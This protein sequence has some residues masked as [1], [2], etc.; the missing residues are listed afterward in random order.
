MGGGP[1]PSPGA[2]HWG[3]PRYFDEVLSAFPDLT[4]ILAHMGLGY[5][6]D[7]VRLTERHANVHTDTSLRL[8]RLGRAGNP[9]PAELVALIRRIGV[10]RT[11][12]GTNYPFVDPRAYRERL[13]ALPLS[14]R[15]RELIAYRNF[16]AVLPPVAQED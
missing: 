15:E 10:D 16:M 4:L 14:E 8:S 3:R 13:Q 2:D 9:T 5:E 11:L 12:F 6:E 7:V 1:P